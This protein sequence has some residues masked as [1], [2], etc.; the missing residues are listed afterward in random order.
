MFAS[1]HTKVCVGKRMH[2]R[3]GKEKSVYFCYCDYCY[4]FGL[5]GSH[6][7]YGLEDLVDLEDSENAKES[8]D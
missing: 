4:Y 1:Y 2:C 6:D 3:L 7:Y 8:V 5:K